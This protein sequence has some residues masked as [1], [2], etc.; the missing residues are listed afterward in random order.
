MGKSARLSLRITVLLLSGGCA[1]HPAGVVDAV[2]TVY[3]RADTDATEIVSPRLRAAATVDDTVAVEASHTVDIWTGASVDVVTAAT[4]AIEERR[5]ELTL[6]GGYR[7]DDVT[8]SAGYRFSTEPDYTAHGG[9]AGVVAELFEKNTTLA[10]TALGSRESV[11]R[12]GDPELGELQWSA[13]GRLTFAQIITESMLFELGW[14]TVRIGGF[15]ASPYRWVAIGV[16]GTC[17]GGAPHCIPEL[18]PDERYRHAATVAARFAS[19]RLMSL[20][21]DYRFYFDSWGL[22]SHAIAPDVALVIARQGTLSLRYRY[23]TQGEATFYRPRYFNVA[24][25]SFATRDRKLSALYTHSLGVGYTHDIPVDR[26]AGT[27][28]VVGVQTTATRYRYLAFVG[29]DVVHAIEATGLFGLRADIG[30]R[31]PAAA[32]EE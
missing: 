5:H 27:H 26:K 11:G 12:A 17:A 31:R 14:E 3:V 28:V 15:Q 1:H 24:D 7:V 13:G 25:T 9:T 6:G 21:A 18:V 19:S 16:S 4:D 20:G 2:E 10:L 22:Q 23:Y 29:L 30:V 32:E 8:I